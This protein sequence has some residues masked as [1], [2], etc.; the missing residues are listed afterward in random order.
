MIHHIAMTIDVSDGSYRFERV[1]YPPILGPVDYAFEQTRNKDCL[2]IGKGLFAGSVLPGSNR[3]ILAARSPLWGGFYLSTMG[4]AA[5]VFDTLGIEF[6][7]ILGCASRPSVLLLKREAGQVHLLIDPIDAKTIWKGGYEGEFGFYALHQSIFDRY[8]ARFSECRILATGPAAMTTNM[9]A[10]G[11]API[12][13]G[14]ITPVD[15]WAGRGGLGS[16]LVRDHNIVGMIYGGDYDEPDNWKDRKAV[17]GEF[18]R[19]FD[20]TMIKT[21]REM[22]SKYRFDPE[23]DSGG[24]LGVNFSNLK[25]WLLSFNYKSIYM[26]DAARMKIH[27][28]MIE[29]HYLRQFNEETIKTKSFANCGEPCPAVCKKMKDQYKKDYEPYQA[30]GPLV[31]IF[32]QRAAELLTRRCDTAGFDAIQL[33]GIIAWLMELLDQKQIEPVDVGVDTVPRFSPD[34]FDVV[35]DS[36]HNAKIGMAIIDFLLSDKA[37]EMRYGIRRAARDLDDR[38]EI[39]SKDLAVYNAHGEDGCMAPNQYWAPGLFAPMP[40]MGKYFQF[41]KTEFVP[42]FELGKKSARRMVLELYSDN[43]GMCR[44]HRGWVEKILPDLIEKHY[45]ERIDFDAHHLALVKKIHKENKPVFWESERIVDMMH[46]YL[47]KVQSDD[48]ELPK[49]REL[50]DKNKSEAARKYWE[51]IKKGIDSVLK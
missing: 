31:G 9:G 1:C 4:G 19:R 44:F 41:Y 8:G 10:I 25:D 5:L 34:N 37:G 39:N 40:I 3:L 15:T 7:S 47:N 48:P 11:S 36:M 14:R 49:W 27:D 30:L 28:R 13:K 32:D 22:T 51:E 45:G 38:L 6:V 23:V 12:K 26:D 17:D 2:V 21:D 24:T 18:I 29:S 16:K 35:A 42:P 33:G 20:Q 46:T 43:N 50:F